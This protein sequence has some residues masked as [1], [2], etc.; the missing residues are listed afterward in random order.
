MSNYLDT[1]SGAYGGYLSDDEKIEVGEFAA[2]LIE[3]KTMSDRARIDSL[4]KEAAASID[5]YPDF[6]RLMGLFD[7]LEKEAEGSGNSWLKNNLG[8]VLGASAAAFNLTQAITTG[9]KKLNRSYRQKQAFAQILRDYPNLRHDVNTPRYFQLIID[10]S[11]AIA[12]NP[13]VA[14]NVMEE[15]RKLGPAAI[16]P[17][18]INELLGLQAAISRNHVD[19]VKSITEP[20]AKSF[21]VGAKTYNDRAEQGKTHKEFLVKATRARTDLV[22]AQ[23]KADEA[24][25]RLLR[26][27]NISDERAF[28]SK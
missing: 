10:F 15:F 16:T 8:T 25:A 5:N 9:A 27:S 14:G 12:E 3:A 20:L 21:E 4:I 24:K 13:L 28:D 22:N 26:E 2:K 19:E 1:Y 6:E 23:A 7:W 11:P 17:V 18:R